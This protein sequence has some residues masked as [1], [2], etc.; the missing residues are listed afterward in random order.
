MENPCTRQSLKDHTEFLERL[1]AIRD[2]PKDRTKAELVL[3]L[4]WC[5]DQIEFLATALASQNEIVDKRKRV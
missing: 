1:Y 5:E 3:S 4:A 2:A